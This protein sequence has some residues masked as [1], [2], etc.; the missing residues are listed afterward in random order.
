MA[1]NVQTGT[2]LIREG[3]LLPGALNVESERYTDH[4]RL[5]SAPHHMG[6]DDKIRAAGWN[7][8]FM[9]AC[10][11]AIALGSRGIRTTGRAL[12]R[13]LARQGIPVREDV[14]AALR[15]LTADECA[16]LDVWHAALVESEA[17]K[18]S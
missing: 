10:T 8:F 9:A 11:S 4:W 3:L 1:N 6:L 12:K 5:V 2:V 18:S 14:R 17:R 13:L 15:G 16:E 7:F